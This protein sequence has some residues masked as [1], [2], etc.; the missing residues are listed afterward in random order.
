MVV[1]FLGT[2]FGVLADWLVDGRAAAGQ[3]GGEA[4]WGSLSHRGGQQHMYG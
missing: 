3:G 1:G 4:G 2:G